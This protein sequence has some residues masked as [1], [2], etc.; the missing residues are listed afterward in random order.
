MKADTKTM[1]FVLFVAKNGKMIIPSTHLAMSSEAPPQ[2]SPRGG[3]SFL[4]WKV[5][6]GLWWNSF[7][8]GKAGMGL[9]LATLSELRLAEGVILNLIISSCN[10]PPINLVRV[11]PAA[12][13]NTYSVAIMVVLA[14]RVAVFARNPGLGGGA[15]RLSRPSAR[16]PPMAPAPMMA[17]VITWQVCVRDD[18]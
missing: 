6:M 12:N 9:P 17:I 8:L 13:R 1:F 7:P 15:F 18:R 11:T 16:L 2:P 14:P 10:F 4:L 3:S 5:G